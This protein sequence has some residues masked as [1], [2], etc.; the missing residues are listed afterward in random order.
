[1]EQ[2]GSFYS[3]IDEP[4]RVRVTNREGRP[5]EGVSVR[6]TP[7]TGTLSATESRT[8]AEGVAS[9]A[10][11][12]RNLTTGSFPLGRHS[13]WAKVS[14]LQEVQFTAYAGRGMELQGVSITPGQVNVASGPATVKVTVNAQN[15]AGVVSAGAFRLHSPS[16]P[17]AG[18][19]FALTSS[20]VQAGVWR[21]TFE[22]SVQIPQGAEAGV[23]KLQFNL[24][25][26][27]YELTWV[28]EN[29]QF[30][31]M[32]HQLTVTAVP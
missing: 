8:N 14:D 3:D 17:S 24:R 6:W 22:A 4:L 27:Q 28:S 31:S 2:V 1:N 16:G 25:N 12:L 26:P 19:T 20:S 32:P 30:K 10:W 18:A 23:W 21:G 7:T 9:V 13:V 15:D 11:N 29:L 5:L